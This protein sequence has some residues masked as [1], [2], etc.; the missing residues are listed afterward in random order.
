MEQLWQLVFVPAIGYLFL[1]NNQQGKMLSALQTQLS[2]VQNN[3]L[4]IKST[5][6]SF[7]KTETDVLKETLRENTQALKQLS[8]K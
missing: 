8:G 7:V 1:Q 2:V 4:S 5:L 3:L 6:D